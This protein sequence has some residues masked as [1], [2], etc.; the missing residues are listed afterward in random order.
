[1]KGILTFDLPE[2]RADFEVSCKAGA[3]CSALDDVRNCLRNLRKY[4]IPADLKTREDVV[5][6]I[7]NRYVDAT[8]ELPHE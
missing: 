5:E 4:G 2:E 7:W 8:E 6:Y 1:M 3:F